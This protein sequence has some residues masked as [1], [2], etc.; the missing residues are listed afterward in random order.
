[1]QDEYL[2]EDNLQS[3]FFFLAALVAYMEVPGLGSQSDPQLQPMQ[4]LQ[5]HQILNPLH[6]S[7]NPHILFH[8]TKKKEQQQ[9]QKKPQQKQS[10]F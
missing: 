4:Q 5:Q 8:K 1:M 10:S 2:L 7:K 6:H 3:F 9:Q